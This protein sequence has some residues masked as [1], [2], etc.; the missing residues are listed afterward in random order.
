M[1]Y[2]KYGQEVKTR[3]LRELQDLSADDAA[4]M[5]RGVLRALEKFSTINNDTE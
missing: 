4:R 2:T 1:L 5:A 3:A